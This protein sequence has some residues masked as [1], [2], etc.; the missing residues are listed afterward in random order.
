MQERRAGG[1]FASGLPSLFASK[2]L[3]NSLVLARSRV[4]MVPC[5]VMGKGPVN[6]RRGSPA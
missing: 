4:C 3:F 2:A 5:V 6:G 1:Y